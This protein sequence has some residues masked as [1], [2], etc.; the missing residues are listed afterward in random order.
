MAKSNFE[1]LNFTLK[2]IND[3]R[4]KTKKIISFTIDARDNI[5][6]SIQGEENER[7]FDSKNEEISL[8]G[9]VIEPFL[10][11]VINKWNVML[12]Y[13]TYQVDKDKVLKYLEDLGCSTVSIYE[14]KNV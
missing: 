3:K 9:K 7:I 4:P 8:G 10:S 13:I 2:N 14:K 12:P 6:L 11:Y 1:K 5:I